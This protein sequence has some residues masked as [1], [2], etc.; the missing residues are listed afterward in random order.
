MKACTIPLLVALIAI[1]AAAFAADDA[2]LRPCARKSPACA[3]P[4][5]KRNDALEQRWFRR[6][7]K[8]LRPRASRQGPKRPRRRPRRP[9]RW[10]QRLQSEHIPDPVRPV[11]QPFRDPA[12]YR[13]TGFH[14]PKRPAGRHHAPAR[15]SLAEE[16]T[17][18][19]CQHRPTVS[20]GAMNFLSMP[21]TRC[22][23]RKPSSRPPP[24]RRA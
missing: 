16:R 1:P 21:T 7:R 18:H 13:I 10:R 5:K 24:W 2:D 6:S 11:Q 3:K 8:P 4:M 9:H 17:G 22:P 20:T 15:F 23:P 14:L 12:G 19:F